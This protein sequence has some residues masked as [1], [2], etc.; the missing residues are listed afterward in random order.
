MLPPTL[1]AAVFVAVH[2]LPSTKAT[3]SLAR[4]L[5]GGAAL[6]PHPALDGERFRRGAIYVAPAD[7]HLLVERGVM[8]LERSP[9]ES[10]SRPSVDALFRSAAEAYGRRVVGVLLTGVL[11]DGSVGLWQIRKRGGITIA[12]DPAEAMYPDMPSSALTSVPVHRCLPLSEIGPTLIALATDVP[13]APPLSGSRTARVLIV[14]DERIV[15]LDLENR[16]RELGYVV[17]GSVSSGEV[18]LEA[19]PT[20]MPDVVLMDVHLAGAMSGT[21]AARL[22]WQQHQLPVVYVTAYADDR[23]LDEAKVSTPYGYIVKP[24]RPEQIHTAV[25]LALDRYEREM[26]IG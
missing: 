6:T 9:R 23:T 19:A 20:V 3:D 10:Q 12:Q 17:V 15:A 14:E 25:Q 24:Y 13:G 21:E 22:L 7:M 8:R 4:V 2:R 26:R 16:L 11:S 1:P 18:A 5:T